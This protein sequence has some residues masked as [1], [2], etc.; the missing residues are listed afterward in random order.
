MSIEEI[1]SLFEAELPGTWTHDHMMNYKRPS[2]EEVLQSS[3]TP[4]QSAVIFLLYPSANDWHF[5]LLKRHDYEGVHSG[6]VGFPGGRLEPEET[7]VQ[8]ALRE[9]WEETGVTLDQKE[10]VRELTSLYIPPSNFIVQ[11]F[12]AIIERN[13]VWKFDQ[14][15][16]ARGIEVPLK[17]LTVKNN[18]VDSDVRISGGALRLNVKSF[19]FDGET[20]WGATAMI[21]SE[22]KEILGKFSA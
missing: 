14:R 11:P 4:R 1:K 3:V 20:V 7:P 22:C 13:P 10:I 21:L 2:V 19:H 17:N 15:E 18:I 16:V 6:Q 9:F 12:V 5:L 8:A